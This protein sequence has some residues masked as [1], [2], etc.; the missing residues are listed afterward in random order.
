VKSDP[1]PTIIRGFPLR[2]RQ[3]IVRIDRD[4]FMLNPTSCAPS[5]VL[6]SVLSM[7]G[8]STMR[9]VPFTMGGCN[10]L[11]MEQ[12]LAIRFTNKTQ[13][14]DGDHPGISAALTSPAGGANLRKAVVKLPLSIALDPDNAQQLCKPEQRAALACPARSII[15]KATAVSVLPH[16]LTGPVYFVEGRRTS[17]SGRVIKTL[18]K[19]WIPLSADGVTIDVDASSDVD[20]LDRLVTTF[21]KLPDAPIT[22]F[23]LDISGG[24][25]GVLVVSGT[26]STCERT[27]SVDSQLTGQN[28]K[29]LTSS[30]DATI[31]GCKPKV[32]K[33]AASKTAVTFRVAGVG[34]GKVTVSGRGVA[35]ASR[36]LKSAS[37]ASVTAKL[38]PSARRSLQ[39]HKRVTVRLTVRFV[40]RGGKAMSVK[41]TITVT[42]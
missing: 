13:H 8:V 3:V 40:P 14:D 30:F 23:K 7:D 18:P 31:D 20:E 6:T 34:A 28:G 16:P 15:G 1:L 19:L 32:I 24:R 27:K 4:G 29:I 2:L 39:R 12:K 21:D 42:R 41:Q 37:V 36:S 10:A 33:T 9:S 17:A 35:Q 26:P 5:N 38:S 22:S 11:D 25:H